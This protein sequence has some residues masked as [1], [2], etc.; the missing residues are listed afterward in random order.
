MSKWKLKCVNVKKEFRC[1]FTT[2]THLSW[3]LLSL[4]Y[5]QKTF[6]KQLLLL[7]WRHVLR[8][9][10]VSAV[11]FNARCVNKLTEQTQTCLLSVC[12]SELKQRSSLRE[13]APL[14]NITVLS[15]CFCGWTEWDVF[16]FLI[17]PVQLSSMSDWSVK[18]INDP[19]GSGFRVSGFRVSDVCDGS[20]WDDL[21]AE[22]SEQEA[23]GEEESLQQDFRLI[24][25]RVMLGWTLI[26]RL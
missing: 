4:S 10:L 9:Q 1:R 5:C 16:P 25:T 21:S 23:G 26:L 17:P 18:L 11:S 13:D 7:S 24:Q 3:N 22:T 8:L 12:V 2:L 15:Q 20:C 14:C 6:M 19:E